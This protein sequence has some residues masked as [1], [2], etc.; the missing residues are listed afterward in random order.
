MSGD[1]SCFQT[2]LFERL[3]Y[4]SERGEARWRKGNEALGQGGNKGMNYK[5]FQ[6]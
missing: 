3:R 2:L 1:I 5:P 6:I 4:C